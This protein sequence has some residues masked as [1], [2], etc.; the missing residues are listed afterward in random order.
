LT[1]APLA[2]YRRPLGTAMRRVAR[3]IFLL[4]LASPGF[5][6]AG[7]VFYA[8]LPDTTFGTDGI[9]HAPGA[10]ETSEGIAGFAI[11]PDGR[12][13]AA[14]RFQY[15]GLLAR[16]LDDGSLDP[17][18][19]TGGVVTVM[20][21]STIWWY[22][23]IALDTDGKAIV[24][25]HHFATFGDSDP[26]VVRHDDG[27][28]VDT[29]FGTDGFVFLAPLG[30][31]TVADAPRI[32]TDGRIL[33]GGATAAGP[34]LVRLDGSGHP[35]P[36]FGSGGVLDLDIG[37]APASSTLTDHLPLPDGRI[38]VLVQASSGPGDAVLVLARYD[39]SGVL[40]PTFGDGGVARLSP[41]TGAALARQADG[42]LLVN[43]G[44]P[45][46]DAVQDRIATWRFDGDGIL[47]PGFGNGG[48]ASV[49]YFDQTGGGPIAVQADGKIVVAVRD[50][51]FGLYIARYQP[52]GNLDVTF[53]SQGVTYALFPGLGWSGFALAPDGKLV[54]SSDFLFIDIELARWR[55]EGDCPAAPRAGCKVARS[56]M[57]LR[58]GVIDAQDRFEWT[59]TDGPATSLS[60]LGNP[61][62]STYYSLCLY[63]EAGPA[64]LVFE[65]GVR[66]GEFCGDRT[67]WQPIRDIGFQYNVPSAQT[68]HGTTRFLLKAGSAGKAK[69][70]LKARGI[71]LSYAHPPVSLSPPLRMQLVG[72]N[73]LCLEA[74]YPVAGV[75]RNDAR[76]FKARS[77]D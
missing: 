55:M 50:A 73:D 58:E 65:T 31:D 33:I 4:V 1:P 3:S 47:D 10:V 7:I 77:T 24:T 19:G 37:P 13:V 29:G 52:D 64:R 6:C 28:G 68:Y 42:K 14:G 46:V 26:F 5:A 60:E 11:L 15:G 62:E 30:V 21:D 27:G 20:P 23:G 74:R 25:G 45:G 8:G 57:R 70:V 17:S 18:F 63:D 49:P 56:T 43:G 71:Q 36:T 48:V 76:E 53:G 54:G 59:W 32:Q 41:A 12:I 75:V 35:D 22:A 51:G 9:V 39:G 67:C 2:W 69:A 44:V 61:V 16:Y 72:S 34:V 40:D 66:A 38:V